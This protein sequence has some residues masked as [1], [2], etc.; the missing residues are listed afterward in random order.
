MK[1]SPAFSLFSKTL[2]FIY[3]PRPADALLSSSSSYSVAAT[4]SGALQ[5]SIMAEYLVTSC[6]FSP[7]NATKAS[8][9]LGGITSRRQPD[10]VLGFLK[11]HGF[12]DTHMKDLL[13]W[14]PRCL[15]LDVETTLAAKF[16]SLQELGFSQSDIT[17]LV[18][19]NPFAINYDVRT[20]VHKIRFWQGLIGS[21]DVLVNLF[22]SRRWFLG[23]SIEKRIQPNIEMLRSCGIT[24]QKLRTILRYR[25]TMVTQR[26]ETL[27]ALISRVEGFGVPRTSG[28]FHWTLLMLSTLSVERCNAQKKLFEAFGWSEADFLDAIRKTPFF[29]TGSLKNLKMKMEFLVN[30]AGYAP[31]YIA[32]RPVLL[33]LSLEKRLIPRYQLMAALKSRGLCAGHPK[34]VTYML[35]PEKK[36]LERYVIIYKKQFPE[37]IELYSARK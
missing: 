1:R 10:S 13:S 9:L 4:G 8:N 36:F 19:A 7:E 31:S 14:N 2:C 6:G 12:D 35:C 30:E 28:R 3:R 32:L 25:P 37:L 27:R 17:H 24:D 21:N 34:S 15:L 5:P 26:A 29:L 11:S 22:K 33:T 23:F 18:L 16:R 20:V